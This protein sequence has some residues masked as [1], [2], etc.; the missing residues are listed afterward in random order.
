[1]KKLALTLYDMGLFTV[2]GLAVC[3]VIE[4][5]AHMFGLHLADFF[6]FLGPAGVGLYHSI[7]HRPNFCSKFYYD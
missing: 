2:I 1:M 3:V 6:I 5:I 4:G 7:W